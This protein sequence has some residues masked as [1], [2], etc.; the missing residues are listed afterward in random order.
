MDWN[1]HTANTIAAI[2]APNLPEVLIDAISAVAHFEFSAIF[3]YPP[4]H[5]PAFLY[6]GFGP[7]RHE[8]VVAPYLRGD[9][10][11]DPFYL[12]CKNEI[13]P[14]LYRMSDL[15]EVDSF[16]SATAIPKMRSP[17]IS[18]DPEF[19]SEE[20]GFVARNEFG[21]YIVL[22]LMRPNNH[23]PFSTSEFDS[24]NQIKPIV[25]SVLA[26]HWE[27]L[28]RRGG[29]QNVGSSISDH[30]ETAFENFGVSILTSRE[31]DVAQMIL[32]GHTSPS[33]AKNLRIATS[34]VKIHRKNLYAK[35]NISS[36]SELWAH[37]LDS[38]STSLDS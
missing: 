33:I 34:T 27:K 29:N 30:V 11:E 12:A 23:S 25:L 22:S 37:Y 20:I 24:L 1:T 26:K 15:P 2:G 21:A 28:G 4:H 35:L 31:R 10:E 9:F 17:C 3:G 5:R 6:D 7:K 18:S 19:L 8:S 32:R 14:D 13:S 16:T 36:Q 38:F